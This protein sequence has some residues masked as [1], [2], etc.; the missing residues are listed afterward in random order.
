MSDAQWAKIASLLPD[1]A[2]DPGRT[3]SDNQ[4]FMNGCLWVLRS[5]AHWARSAG[6]VWQ[7]EVGA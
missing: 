7:V 6:A 2:G 3:G 5:G 4:L 1:K